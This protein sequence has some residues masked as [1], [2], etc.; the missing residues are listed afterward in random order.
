LPVKMG[1]IRR[2]RIIAEGTDLQINTKA[3]ALIL[4][5]KDIDDNA[6]KEIGF[7]A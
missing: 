1:L 6:D 4:I 2:L 5:V 7:A 3:A